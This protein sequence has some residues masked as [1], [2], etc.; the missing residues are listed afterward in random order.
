MRR[1]PLPYFPASNL[2]PSVIKLVYGVTCLKNGLEKV[3][4]LGLRRAIPILS[5]RQEGLDSFSQSIVTVRSKV[6]RALRL[7]RSEVVEEA[8]GPTDPPK[9]CGSE[10]AVQALLSGITAFQHGIN[11]LFEEQL[12]EK[13]LYLLKKN[14][15]TPLG[16]LKGRLLS[17]RKM[18]KK[19]DAE[20]KRF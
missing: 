10:Q 8:K 7:L 3:L 2:Q 16:I 12:R 6:D 15:N 1:R 18:L 13:I 17:I 9:K 5:K 14:K 19:L 20:L 4:E 11:V